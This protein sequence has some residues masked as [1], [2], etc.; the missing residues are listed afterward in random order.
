[1]YAA[2]RNKCSVNACGEE[3][4]AGLQ[5]AVS[6]KL[7]LVC[8]QNEFRRVPHTHFVTFTLN[9]CFGDKVLMCS[10]G[11]L[12]YTMFG[13]QLVAVIL[14]QPPECQ[15]SF[16]FRSVFQC[17]GGL[18]SAAVQASYS[19]YKMML[20]CLCSPF[21]FIWDELTLALLTL[22]VWERSFWGWKTFKVYRHYYQIKIFLLWNICQRETL[23]NKI[24][25][26]Y[27]LPRFRSRTLLMCPKPPMSECAWWYIFHS[28]CLLEKASAFKGNLPLLSVSQ[29]Y[30]GLCVLLNLPVCIS[31]LQPSVQLSATSTRLNLGF[32]FSARHIIAGMEQVLLCEGVNERELQSLPANSLPSDQQHHFFVQPQ[33]ESLAVPI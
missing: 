25:N 21:L 8:V 31:G 7:F 33:L 14:A 20:M 4:P 5:S 19:C 1:M 2:L 32:V 30:P 18:S 22:F 6:R 29:H 11:W 17:C 15:G 24:Q 12:L 13:L 3:W 16:Y 10:F 23:K 9:L 27:C 26:I 28:L